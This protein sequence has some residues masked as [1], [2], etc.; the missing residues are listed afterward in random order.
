MLKKYWFAAYVRNRGSAYEVSFSFT[1]LARWLN[2]YVGT[3]AHQK[4]IPSIALDMPVAESTALLMGMQDGDG[5]KEDYGYKIASTSQVMLR[6]IQMLL[7][8]LGRWGSIG[9]GKDPNGRVSIIKGRPARSRHACGYIGYGD[10]VRTRHWTDA[11]NFYIPIKSIVE[12]G[13]SFVMA[14]PSTAPL[15]VYNNRLISNRAG[16]C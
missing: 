9:W 15:L 10:E 6:Q 1:W 7:T 14:A 16:D 5:C 2:K 12:V 11:D 4:V 13:P 8:K 3:R